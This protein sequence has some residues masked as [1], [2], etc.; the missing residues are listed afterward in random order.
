MLLCFYSLFRK[1]EKK[2]GAMKAIFLCECRHAALGSFTADC[3]WLNVYIHIEARRSLK[4]HCS[5]WKLKIL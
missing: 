3:T 5:I 1:K 2:K 4:L